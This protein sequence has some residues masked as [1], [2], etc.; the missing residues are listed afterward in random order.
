[1]NKRDL[2]WAALGGGLL[3]L[4][5]LACQAVVLMRGGL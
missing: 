2:L 1:M 3:F 4:L 5:F